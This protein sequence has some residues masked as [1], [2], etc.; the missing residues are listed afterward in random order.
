MH[1]S[2]VRIAKKLK[3]GEP[4]SMK[5]TPE[6]AQIRKNIEKTGS[7]QLCFF[8]LRPGGSIYR[9]WLILGVKKV[10]KNTQK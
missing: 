10:K 5:M 1:Q 8:G 3:K 2:G 6:S 4:R 7:K 9:F